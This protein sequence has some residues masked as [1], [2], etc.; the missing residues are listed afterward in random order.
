MFDTMTLTKI[1]GGFC[2]ALL[3]FLLGGWAAETIYHSGAAYGDQQAYI[4][5]VED[6]EGEDV[7]VEEGP[8][9]EEVFAMA[10]PDAGQALW[11]GCQA[12]HQLEPGQNATGPYLHGVVNR[13]I[14][15]AAGFS[16]SA[17]LAGLDDVWSPENLDAFIENPRGFA[18]GTT[19]TYSGMR[20]Q[21][22][23]ANL[24]AYL[25]SIDD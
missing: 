14:G 2:G 1:V 15:E 9:F 25:D 3:I 7:A 19:M 17:A 13:P 8:G 10:D 23:R 22:D 12:C 4:I 24:I 20:N 5:P 18:P 6:A 16:Y 11:R 21:Q